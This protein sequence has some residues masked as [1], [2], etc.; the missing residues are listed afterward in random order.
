MTYVS[1]QRPQ[2][3][4]AELAGRARAASR[5]LAKLPNQARSAALIAVA[6]G[7][8]DNAREILEANE[9]DRRVAEAAVAAGVMSSAMFARLQ[10]TKNGIFEMATRVRDVAR[11]PDPLGRR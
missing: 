4:A 8:E 3:A 2:L 7:I 9:N 1:Q 11:L 5:A 6:K 10:V